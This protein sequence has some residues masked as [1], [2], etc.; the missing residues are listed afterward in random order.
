MSSN[1]GRPASIVV[2]REQNGNVH[3]RIITSDVPA[4]VAMLEAQ[5]YVIVDIIDI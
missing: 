3:Y 5:G 2:Y 4:T 1:N